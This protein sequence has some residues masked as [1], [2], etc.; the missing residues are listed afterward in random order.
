MT[1]RKPKLEPS[2]DP[3]ALRLERG[4][5]ETNRQVV[6][7]AFV[8]PFTRHGLVAASLCEKITSAMPA[9]D[10]PGMTEYAWEMKGRAQKVA[11]G[12]LGVLSEVLMAQALTLDGIFTELARRSAGNMGEYL[13]AAERYMRLALKAQAGSRATLEALAKL[14]LPR[15]QTVRHVHINEGGQAVIAD[16]VHHHPRGQEN[17][18]SVE[19]S[20]ATGVAG[21][22]GALP[23]PDPHGEAVPSA[24]CEREAPLSDAWRHKQRRASRKS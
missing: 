1:T 7:R 18:K 21:G 13:D 17:A 11:A 5:N 6:A 8:A 22:G 15:E 12:D 10:K 2:P 19:Q 20:H 3:T 14:H 4:A 16:Q 23:S 24:R 9:D